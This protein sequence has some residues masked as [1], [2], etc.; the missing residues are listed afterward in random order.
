MNGSIPLQQAWVGQP[1]NYF[2]PP[3][4][5]VDPNDDV[6]GYSAD[7]V[8][9]KK[10]PGWLQFNPLTVGFGGVPQSSDAGNYT[11]VLSATD[12]ICPKYLQ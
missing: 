10:L 5:F 12:H 7:L 6:I 4:L 1:F 3:D 11:I 9:G 8:G 2:V